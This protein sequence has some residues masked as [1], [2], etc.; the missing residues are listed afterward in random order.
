MADGYW[1]QL[2][3][4]S[5][6]RGRCKDQRPDFR[7]VSCFLD[8]NR[9]SDFTCIEKGR[10]LTQPLHLQKISNSNV[11][12]QKR[13]QNYDYTTIADRLRTV[14]WSYDSHPTSVVK[15]VYGIPTF[16][17]TATAVLSKDSFHSYILILDILLNIQI[18]I[19]HQRV[20]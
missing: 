18:S 12:T 17:L 20:F 3:H 1:Y 10:D 5:K 14:S 16:K 7:V 11:T 8:C 19:K 15:S 13:H 2:F 6:K 4:V 9:N